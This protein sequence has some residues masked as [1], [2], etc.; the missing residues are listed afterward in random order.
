[1]NDLPDHV[2]KYVARVDAHMPTLASDDDRLAFLKAEEC[3]WLG[4]Y[5]AFTSNVI[6]GGPVDPD[7]DAADYVLTIAELGQRARK[8]ELEAV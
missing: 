6:A 3:K 1:M 5:S 7:V 8:F 4:R 2:R